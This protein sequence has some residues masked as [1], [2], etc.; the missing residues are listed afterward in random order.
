MVMKIQYEVCIVELPVS[1]SCIGIVHA[2]MWMA[3]TL[4][5]NCKSAISLFSGIR[6][7]VAAFL[8]A[9]NER[10]KRLNSAP[11]TYLCS[12][13]AWS[14]KNWRTQWRRWQSTASTRDAAA[15]FDALVAVAAFLISFYL[16]K[17]GEVRER[18]IPSYILWEKYTDWVGQPRTQVRFQKQKEGLDKA[19][20]EVH[21]T[22]KLQTVHTKQRV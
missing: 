16:R 3:D 5:Q 11:P 7:V 13:S 10:C 9:T 12:K 2:R 17:I 21:Q 22:A 1:E 6:S 20:K 18:E 8:Y 14:Q 19:N 15:F 4:L